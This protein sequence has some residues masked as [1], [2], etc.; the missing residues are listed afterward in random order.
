MESTIL[1]KL[2][3]AIVALQKDVG[4]IKVQQAQ[5][6]LTITGTHEQ[7]TKTNGRVNKHDDILESITK[8]LAKQVHWNSKIH[9]RFEA[10]Q[11]WVTER[12]KDNKEFAERE[13]NLLKTNIGHACEADTEVEVAKIQAKT[14]TWKLVVTSLVSIVTAT[15]ASVGIK[16][17]LN[18]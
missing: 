18:Q 17:T 1:T 15:L 9:G 2:Y 3:E 5:N 7:T 11:Q 6:T 4:E 13:I 14:D 12:I 10:H 16:L 8:T